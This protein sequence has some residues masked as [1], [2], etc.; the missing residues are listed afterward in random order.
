MARTNQSEQRKLEL[1]AQL[2]DAR[3]SMLGAKLLLDEQLADK[4]A[5]LTE[6]LNVPKRVK[7]AF[8]EQPIKSFSVALASGLGASIF[9]KKK[10]KKQNTEKVAKASVLTGLFLAVLKP[11][12]QRLA[13]QYS[14]QWLAQRANHKQHDRYQLDQVQ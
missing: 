14:Q 9:F 10:P 11:I 13:L 2:E 5:S 1:V 4:K 12:L 7:K 6:A 3:T 8:M